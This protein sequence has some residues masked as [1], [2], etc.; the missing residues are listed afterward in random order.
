MRG[1]TVDDNSPNTAFLLHQR[2]RLRSIV[3]SVSVSVCV[4][5][6]IS[7]T[8]RA[9]F[10]KFFVHVADGRVSVLFQ[11]GNEIPREG[12]IL[13]VFFPIDNALYNIAFGTHT[14]TA[15]SIEMPFGMMSG[16]GPR[17]SVLRGGD[18]PEGEGAIL[19]GNMC[20]TSL[21]PL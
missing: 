5:E 9:I 8:Q 18:D 12:T 6:D 15:E 10:T 16:L 4:C 13:V 19:G 3:M 1:G 14:K 2:A 20:P 7:E 21:T 11:R 17:N